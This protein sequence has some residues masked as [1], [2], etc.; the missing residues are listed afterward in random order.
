MTRRRNPHRIPQYE[1]ATY[2][3]LQDLLATNVLR[4]RKERGWTQAE[5]AHRCEMTTWQYQ[6][7]EGGITNVTLTTLARIIDGFETYITEL[8]SADSITDKQ[9]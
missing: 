5:A 9:K 3:K 7:V 8:V 1:S 6:R 4:L 2:R